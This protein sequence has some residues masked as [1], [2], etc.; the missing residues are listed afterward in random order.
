MADGAEGVP[1]MGVPSY[2]DES[3]GA[4]VPESEMVML[5]SPD[6]REVQRLADQINREVYGSESDGG[7]GGGESADDYCYWSDD[8]T[9]EENVNSDDYTDTT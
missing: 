3:E 4:R 6:P 1:V 5:T 7:G 9:K 2:S 8:E